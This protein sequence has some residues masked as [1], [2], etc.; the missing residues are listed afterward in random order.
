MV[1]EVYKC[2][3]VVVGMGKDIAGSGASEV[4][5]LVDDID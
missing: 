4:S 1:D 3:G 5:E 2:G